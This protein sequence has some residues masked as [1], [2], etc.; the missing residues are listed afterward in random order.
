VVAIPVGLQFAVVG[1]WAM[2]DPRSFFDK[3]ATFQPYNQHLLQ[4]LGAFQVGLGVVLL[5]AA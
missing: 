2:V 3:L 1:V 4:D 5:L